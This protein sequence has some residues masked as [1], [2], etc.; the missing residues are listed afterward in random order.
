MLQKCQAGDI[1]FYSFFIRHIDSH[2]TKPF[3][4]IQ[5]FIKDGFLRIVIAILP[6][7]AIVF[8]HSNLMNDF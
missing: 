5:K 4:L 2:K 1:F 7:N 6:T 8:H 3:F